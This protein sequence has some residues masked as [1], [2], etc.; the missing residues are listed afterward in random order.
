MTA[1][2]VFYIRM[3]LVIRCPTRK[4]TERLSGAENTRLFVF[5]AYDFALF[6]YL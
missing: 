4:P 1:N 2:S 6:F 5:E 3:G